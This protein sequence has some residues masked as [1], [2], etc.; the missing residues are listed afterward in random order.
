MPLNEW[1]NPYVWQ[2]MQAMQGSGG[3]GDSK[4]EDPSDYWNVPE[5]AGWIVPN[6]PDALT[7]WG[8]NMADA[9]PVLS[10]PSRLR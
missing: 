7:P 6:N 8:V 10:A 2:M 3:S 1:N 5:I 9:I 4:D